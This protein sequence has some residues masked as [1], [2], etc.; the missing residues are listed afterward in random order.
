[1]QLKNAV[2]QIEGQYDQSDRGSA[3]ERS[4]VEIK[5]SF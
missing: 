2:G 4:E 5:Y 1:M 3:G